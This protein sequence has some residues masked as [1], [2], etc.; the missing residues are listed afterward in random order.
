[1]ESRTTEDAEKRH[2][3][4]R[5]LGWIFVALGVLQLFMGEWLYGVFLLVYA[6]YLLMMKKVERLP[7]AVRYLLVVAFA[8]F[9]VFM[10]F[11]IVSNLSSLR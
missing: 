8:A 7:K 1:M 5:L 10:L 11:R 4:T 6:V 3:L 2:K 9:A